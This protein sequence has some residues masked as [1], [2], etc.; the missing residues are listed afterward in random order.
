MNLNSPLFSKVK[1]G[2]ASLVLA[3]S[4]Q[5]GCALATDSSWQVVEGS[6]GIAGKGAA[7]IELSGQEHW[8]LS[9]MNQGLILVDVEGKTK[10]RL[11]G[12]FELLDLRHDIAVN[13][14]SFSIALTLDYERNRLIM[15]GLS[16]RSGE[17]ELLAE[18]P[19]PS[20]NIDGL[21][22]YQGHQG[23]LYTFV[24]DGRSVGEQ[25]LLIDGTQGQGGANFSPFIEHATK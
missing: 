10:Q 23:H 15:A 16:P 22:L 18:L 13:N 24:L 3:V 1:S 5:T 19:K 14:Q 25:W 7:A 11:D 20:Y 6:Q 17:L 21:C 2:A 8:L 4:T 12:N 9:S